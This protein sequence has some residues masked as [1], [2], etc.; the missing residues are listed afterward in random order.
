[1]STL[2]VG[3]ETAAPLTR[4]TSPPSVPQTRAVIKP[5]VY[6]GTLGV[7][8]GAGI[9]TL[10]G[11]LISVG[12]ADLRG[13]LGFGVDEAAWITTAYN[14][15]LMFMGPF[16]VYVGGLLGVRRVLLF[17]GTVFI[18]ASLLL[19]FSPNLSVMLFLQVVSG[20][21]SGTFYPLT[22]SYALRSLPIRYTIYGIGA[23]SVDILAATSLAVPLEAWYVEHLSW[24]WLFWH[25]ALVTPLM[26]WCIYRAIPNPPPRPGPKPSLSWAGFLYA[27]LGLSL[28]YGVLDQGER[29]DWLNSGVIV[30]M[31]VTGVFLILVGVIRRWLSPNPAVR[32]PFLANRNT[33][34]LGASLF[35][36]RFVMLAIAF[37][38]PSFLGAIQNYRA[39]QT[40]EVM[41]WVALPQLAMG[42]LTARIMKFVDG[43]LILALGFAI[44][45]A[46][47]LMNA[48]LTIAWAGG[49]FW[50]PQLV[51]A[52]GLSFAFV[53]MVGMIA[54]QGLDT[55][56]LSR[57]F[58]VLTYSAF[59]HT[60][61]LFG[62]E[63]GTAFMQRLVAVREQF[64]SNMLGL[65]VDAGDWLTDE[66]LRMLTG[67]VSSGSSGLE[68]AQ[69]RA[70]VLLGGQ[71]KQQAYTLAFADGFI[72]IAWLA[73]GIIVLIAL[74]RRMRIYF[75]SPSME[76]P[77]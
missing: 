66:R 22:M 28:I 76:P 8:L 71:V 55:G 16:S 23:Y 63:V 17:S 43:R 47:S 68:E 20:L 2:T 25:S 51:M 62:G 19:P 39:L 38:I 13:A 26:M 48:Q 45:A 73:V 35:S 65:G 59:F 27:S 70:V 21:S 12:L 52:V 75:D 50:G 42:Y 29:L 58:D 46:A 36:F 6:V 60:V 41:L 37:L 32:L 49:N 11:R 57:P 69:R 61:R 1:M 64:H 72:T 7:F 54:Q 34:I 33:L 9:A 30:G 3:K 77:R 10:S 53:G 74:M 18:V 44:V 5:N 14:M 4:D 31:L 24:R 15:G 40:G 56:A 67:G